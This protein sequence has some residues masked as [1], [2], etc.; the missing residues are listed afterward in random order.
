MNGKWIV[1]GA[2]NSDITCLILSFL[3]EEFSRIFGQ[4]IMFNKDCI[5]NND[6]SS[7]CPLFI[8]STPLSIRLSQP[9][10]TYFSQTIFQLSHEMCHYALHQTKSNKDITLS[11]FE[12]IVCEAVSLYSLE[13]AS[14]EWYKCG[15]AKHNPTFNQS[16]KEYLDNELKSPSS[17]AFQSCDSIEKLKYYEC[18]RLS[19][20][21]RE[22]L[23]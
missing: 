7:R 1:L 21:Q 15:L 5:I 12:E 6:P 20:T 13:Y 18:Q 19:E 4:N 10:L 14:N 9:D 23:M 22:R 2:E 3:L 16:N 8:H 17:N 11:W